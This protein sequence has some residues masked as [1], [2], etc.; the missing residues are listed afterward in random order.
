MVAMYTYS[1]EVGNL[2]ASSLY[3]K[4]DVTV[5]WVI[6][7]VNTPVHFLFTIFCSGCSVKAAQTNRLSELITT[8]GSL[9]GCEPL[10]KLLSIMDYPEFP[11]HQL[12][13]RLRRLHR[14]PPFDR[15]V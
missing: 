10:N 5:K 11:L 13:R 15:E 1:V 7:P 8:A 4:T 12:L 14:Q 6:T 9:S 3:Y 2:F